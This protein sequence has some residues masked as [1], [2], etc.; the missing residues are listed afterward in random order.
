[1]SYFL[2]VNQSINEVKFIKKILEKKQQK[3]PLVLPARSF[4]GLPCN[5]NQNPKAVV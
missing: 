1:M 5:V 2:Q 4:S 3:E